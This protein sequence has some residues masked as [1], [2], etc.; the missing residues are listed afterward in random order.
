MNA[1]SPILKHDTDAAIQF[2]DKRTAGYP[3]LSAG[4]VDATTG[5]KVKFESKSFPNYHTDRIVREACRAWIEA[6]QGR[7]NIYY[8]VNPTCRPEDNKAGRDNIAAGVSFHVDIDPN[9]GEDQTAALERILKLVQEKCKNSPPSV[10][11]ASGGGV[12]CIFDIVTEEHVPINGDADKAVEFERH[13]LYLAHLLGG[14]RCH[15][16]SRLLRLPGTINIPDEGK[17]AKGR[18]PASAYIVKSTNLQYS[19]ADFPK[20]NAEAGASK[21][22]VASTGVKPDSVKINWSKVDSERFKDRNDLPEGLEDHA[23]VSLMCGDDRKALA[24]EHAK[25]GHT[26]NGGIYKSGS[27]VTLAIAGALKRAVNAGHLTMEDAASIL[28]SPHYLG[29]KHIF[30]G[31][32]S[33]RKVER[34]LSRAGFADAVATNEARTGMKWPDGQNPATYNPIAGYGNTRAAIQALELD[35]RLDTFNGRKTVASLDI[36]QLSGEFSDDVVSVIRNEIYNRFHFYP[37]AEHTQEAL[38]VACRENQ[39]NS[40]VDEIES[41]IWDGTPRLDG[42]FPVYLGSD[43]TPFNRMIGRKMLT[44]A[45]RRARVPGCKFDNVVVLEG[46][47]DI[48]KSMFCKDIAGRE[49][50]FTDAHLLSLD[51]KKHQELLRGKWICEFA[52]LDGLKKV[53]PDRA[54]AIITATHDS[55]RPAYLRDGVDRPRSCIFIGTTNNSRYLTSPNG[56]RRFWPVLVRQYDRAAFLRDRDQLIAE[57]AHYESQG[58]ALYLP[59]DMKP[60]AAEKQASRLVE[61]GLTDV[62]AG[63]S[64]TIARGMAHIHTVELLSILRINP[65]DATTAEM[66]RIKAAMLGLGWDGPKQ[67][68]VNGD[69]R[70][71]YARPVV[72]HPVQMEADI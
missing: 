36:G 11:V 56:N 17:R 24:I 67:V 22:V 42:L 4:H 47:E 59:P 1:A 54:K 66:A 16:V 20:A 64:G 30:N 10:T 43:D 72:I 3:T 37:H 70:K 12:Q 34:A 68:K 29:N 40:V 28:M 7:A 57:A 39:F 27:E 9:E 25:I 14:D 44:A 23:I 5:A 48:G 46:K 61:D 58:E 52:E 51:S 19:V 55:A 63:V 71:G 31:R 62:L 53:D 18:R 38:T 33:H 65:K 15:D 60:V 2:L 69:G 45:V 32:D 41:F 8:H 49:T 35:C 13:N 50:R 6:R 26:V 21:N